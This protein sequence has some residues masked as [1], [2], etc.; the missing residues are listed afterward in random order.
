MQRYGHIA[1]EDLARRQ[2]IRFGWS[3]ITLAISIGLYYLGFFGTTEGPLNPERMGSA[4]NEFGVTGRHIVIFMSL[5]FLV[6]VSWNWV[7][8][9]FRKTVKSAGTAHDPACRPVE[10]G[11]W[12]HTAWAAVLIILIGVII[13]LH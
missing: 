5:L 10:K 1:N 4:M 11:I 13:E 8:N 3:M 12:G 9:L 7:Y 6:S 2:L